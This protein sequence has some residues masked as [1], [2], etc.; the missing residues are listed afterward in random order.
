MLLLS[1]AL[2]SLSPITNADSLDYHVGV[3]L[4][5]LETGSMPVTPEWFHSRLAGNGEVLN[6]IG[7]SVGA[8]QFGALLQFCGLLGITGMIYH[9]GS[10]INL[11][12]TDDKINEAWRLLIVLVAISAP[13]LV[14]LVGSVK[15]QLL[16]IGMTTLALVFSIVLSKNNIDK[17]QSL[18]CFFFICILTMVASQAKVSFL[19][20]GGLVGIFAVYL[21]V[22]KN[23]TFLAITLG[24]FAF[25]IIMLPPAIWKV[26]FFG[27]SLF[28][29]LF[30]PLPGG[31]YGTNEFESFLRDYSDSNIWFPFSLVFPARAGLLSTVIGGGVFL[32]IFIRINRHI[33]LKQMVLL[34]IVYLIFAIFLGPSTSRSY[35]EPYFWLL[36]VLAIQGMP[37]L[38]SNNIKWFKGGVVLQSVLTMAMCWYGI[39]TFLLGSFSPHGRVS[40]MRNLANGYSLMR[41]VGDVLP[42]NAVVLSSHRAIGASP[43]KAIS[44]DWMKHAELDQIKSIPYLMRIKESKVTYLVITE[45][46]YEASRY[47]KFYSQCLVGEAIKSPPLKSATRNPFNKKGNY[48]AWVIPF[49]SQLLPNCV[50]DNSGL[51][52]IDT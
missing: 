1:F 45:Q 16:P 42:A 18:T 52:E 48:T 23:L 9:A 34:S 38:I 22:K 5:I 27:G 13:V 36:I 30:S 35:L 24:I 46:N 41:W 25:V 11:K 6:A 39:S 12:D 2:F 15:P 33:V 40:V 20:G 29:S 32:F 37:A 4:H 43:R 14:F 8:E 17:K 21:M 7:F 47:V 49:D 31:W 19:L 51:Y 50:L 26:V 3:A 10:F 28:E 44:L